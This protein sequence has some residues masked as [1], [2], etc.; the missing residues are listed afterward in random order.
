MSVNLQTFQSVTSKLPE[1]RGSTQRLL[2]S[3]IATAMSGI[4][5]KND[6]QCEVVGVRNIG[7]NVHH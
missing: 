2:Y 7:C 1:Y 3:R 5:S 6:Y 4:E